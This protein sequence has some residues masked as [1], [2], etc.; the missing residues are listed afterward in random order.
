MDSTTYNDV[1]DELSRIAEAVSDE[2]ISLEEALGLY[3]QAAKLGLAACDMSEKDIFSS[4]EPVM[5]EGVEAVEGVEVIEVAEVAEV[6]GVVE[7]LDVIEDA[8]A[9]QTAEDA[10]ASTSDMI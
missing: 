4:E 5:G 6:V 1:K 2:S 3:E 8:N 10:F 9:S 7:A